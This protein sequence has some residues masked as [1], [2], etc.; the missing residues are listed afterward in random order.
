MASFRAAQLPVQGLDLVGAEMLVDELAGVGQHGVDLL[1]DRLIGGSEPVL[2]LGDAHG[3][4]Q[5]LGQ[6]VQLVHQLGRLV[7]LSGLDAHA[8]QRHQDLAAGDQIDQFLLESEEKSLGLQPPVVIG[9]L[10]GQLAAPGRGP[11][12]SGPAGRCRS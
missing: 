3:E 5:R 1:L 6:A 4:L 12:A 8:D 11:S 9:K 2:L 7:E 10:G